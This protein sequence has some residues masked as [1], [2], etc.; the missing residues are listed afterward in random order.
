MARDDI[1][2]FASPYGGHSRLMMTQMQASAVFAR[3]E[4]VVIDANGQL[5]E[6][7]TDE[8][9]THNVIGI[10]AHDVGTSA[11]VG[12][13][14]QTGIDFA[15]GD[16]VAVIPFTPD[17]YFYTEN[18]EHTAAGGF[19]DAAMLID[20]MGSGLGLMIAGGVHGVTMNPGT[21]ASEMIGSVIDLLDTNGNSINNPTG[22]P[23]AI[24]GIVFVVNAGL[25][26]SGATGTTDMAA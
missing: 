4:W 2:P 20:D 9:N 11:A 5:I 13:N 10:A 14:W 16:Q 26:S 25:G 17:Q 8:P 21:A 18:I 22:G 19:G 1:I 24:V 12:T 6:I 15:D 7:T 3:G 23:G